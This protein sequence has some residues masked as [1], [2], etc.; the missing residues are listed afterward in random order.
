MSTLC[1]KFLNLNYKKRPTPFFAVSSIIVFIWL[2]VQ[3]TE[4]KI[5][6]ALYNQ[7]LKLTN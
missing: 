5:S 7:W 6:M 3:F 4:A 1:E 2:N